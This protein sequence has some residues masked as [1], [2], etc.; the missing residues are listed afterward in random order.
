MIH[1]RTYHRLFILTV[2]V[3][4]SAGLFTVSTGPGRYLHLS[5]QNV[6]DSARST[7]LL[8]AYGTLPL[9]FEANSGQTDSSIKF[10]SHGKGYTLYLTATD[11]VLAFGTKTS[12]AMLHLHLTGTTTHPQATGLDELPS[13]TNYFIG[14]DPQKWRT[15]VPA[16]ARI[17]YANVYPGVNLIYYGNQG[18]LEYDFILAPRANPHTIGLTFAGAQSL[19]LDTQ[20]NVIV[21]MV[22]GDIRQEKPVAYQ[23][24]NGVRRV[25]NS[26]YVLAGGNQLGFAVGAYD[27]HL[28][29]TIDP[30]LSYSTYLGGSGND[31]GYAIAVDR[32]GNAY[33]TGYTWSTDF[34]TRH[35][36]Q[37]TFG[38]GEYDGFVAKFNAQG[39][40]LIYSTYLGGNGD[41][42]GY[43]IAADS[44]GNA[45]VTG[46]TTSTD[47]PIAHALQPTNHGHTNAFVTK[48]NANGSALIYSTYLGGS[49][50]D[51]SLAMAVDSS[52]NAYVTGITNS[53]DF[54]TKN[55]LQGTYHGGTDAFVTKINANGSAL[56]Y[57]TYLGGSSYDQG[58]GIAAD[59][60]GNAYVTGYTSSTN[61]PIAHALQGSN[62]GRED[63]FVSKLNASGSVLVY[64]TYLGGSQQDEG[65]GIAVDSTGNAYVTGY[66]QSTDFPTANALQGTINGG[67]DTFVTR[68]NAS[69][70]AL[71]YSTYLGGSSLDQGYGIAVDSAG[72][73]Y[74]I[75]LTYS[76][77]F[78]TVHAIQK[79]NRSGYDTA[80]VA[81]LNAS[82]NAFVYSTYLGG[83][84]GEYGLG[85]AADNAGNTYVTGS[86]VSTDFPTV[87]PVQSKLGSYGYSDA[88][89]SK[90][91]P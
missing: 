2:F 18:Q 91:A 54:P 74:V 15:N 60:A 76:T 57:S 45:Y 24:V 36:L 50:L 78:P 20:G 90:I 73:A 30:V 85:I 38:S 23:E 61:F 32:V 75:G 84:G 51:A 39:T 44:A 46:S 26:H 1:S 68:L 49:N 27:A 89:I 64:S 79:T 56:V 31:Y 35:A 14:N 4:M 5:K 77:D 21:H 28:P 87:H 80:F 67:T 33:V 25:I 48:L 19:R 12:Q 66:T 65:A 17:R 29:L 37:G 59:S 22:N 70:S 8:A 3:A 86:T 34:P 63:A 42:S 9:S 40:A 58:N 41:D 43:G 83:N 53:T 11:P 88:F 55:A 13:K 47:F 62:K 71:V 6:S 10:L 72:N 81:K 16:Y 82:G 69:G 52:D 7:T